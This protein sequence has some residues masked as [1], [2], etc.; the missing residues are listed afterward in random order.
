M[1]G[2]ELSYSQLN[3]LMKRFPEFEL[4]YET[5]SHKK[6][7]TAYNT[8]LAIP[9]GKKCYVW[10]TY[11]ADKDVCYLLELNREKKISRAREV[12]TPFDFTLSLGT[13]VYGTLWEYELKSY[14]VIEDIAFYEGLPMKPLTF[15]ER[16]GFLKRFF[17]KV[18]RDFD[19][20]G[21]NIIFGLP[22]IWN[23]LFKGDDEDNNHYGT[24]PE[25]INRDIAYPIHHIQ[26][27]SMNEIMPY[28]NTAINKKIFM[29]SA[30]NSSKDGGK[31]STDLGKYQERPRLQMDFSKPQ[32]RMK[33][34][35]VVTAD[36]QYDI[37]HLHA[38]GKGSQ[39]VYYNIAYIPSY[40][41]SVF[42]N[43][44]FRNIRENKNLDYI[45]ESDDEED[46]QNMSENKY[47]D[48]NKRIMMECTFHMKF[49]KW[50]P[51]RVVDSRYKVVHISKL[52]R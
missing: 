29:N 3:Y 2:T 7:S 46:F 28:L 34:V 23:V 38:F 15:L 30:N 13:I 19:K 51:L 47:V 44:L 11:Q 16:L 18:T 45:E 49:K 10:F 4:S 5:I 43:G 27:R 20:T 35:F 39:Q 52:I 21:D 48:M 24:I 8:C 42:M 36:I 12:S 32:Y 25:N 31:P 17:G 22:V 1:N 26:Y 40:K 14:F 50:I 33:T 41:T 9:V 6:V 37:Y